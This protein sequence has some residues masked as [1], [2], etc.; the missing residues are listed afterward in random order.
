MPTSLHPEPPANSSRIGRMSLAQ[1]GLF[2]LFG[3]MSVLFGA[4]R[5]GYLVTRAQNPVWRTPEMPPLPLGLLLSTAVIAVLSIF[6]HRAVRAAR[7][8]R[9]EGLQRE[10]QLAFLFAAAFLVCQS[11]N[12]KTMIPA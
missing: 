4:S 11:A 5:G 10:L 6:M 9:N 12:W 3:S 7:E 8:N 2:V 1:L